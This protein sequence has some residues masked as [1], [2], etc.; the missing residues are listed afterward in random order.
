MGSKASG[1]HYTSKAERK[2]VDSKILNSIK[3]TEL[4][5]VKQ[6]NIQKAYWNGQNPWVTLD[7]PNK[8]QTN[9]KKIRVRSNELWGNP[10]DRKSYAMS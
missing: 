5:L 2:N 8:E 1:K 4:P 9:K 3:N 6:M 7:N 10:K